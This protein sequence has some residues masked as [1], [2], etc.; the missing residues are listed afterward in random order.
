MTRPVA[1]F[2]DLNGAE[3]IGTEEVEVACRTRANHKTRAATTTIITAIAAIARYAFF[4]AG[5]IEI[6]AL[7]NSVSGAAVAAEFPFT[8][9]INLYPRRGTVSINRGW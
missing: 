1:N 4:G 6:P 9:A 2:S 5:E 7:L 8:S 3:R